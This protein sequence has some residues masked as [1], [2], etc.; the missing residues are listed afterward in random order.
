[1]DEESKNETQNETKR[2]EQEVVQALLRLYPMLD[3]LQ[4]ETILS[5]TEDELDVYLKNI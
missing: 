3:Q 5:F 2:P 4:A 1:M